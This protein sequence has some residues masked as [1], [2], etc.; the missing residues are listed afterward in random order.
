MSGW[1]LG[2]HAGVVHSVHLQAGRAISYRSRRIHTASAV[3]GGVSD[4]FVFGSSIFAFGPAALAHELSPELDTAQPV[5][6]AGQSRGLSACPKHDP[7]TGDL[8]LLALA[9][10]G[11]Q[12]HVTVSSGA[13]TRRIRPITD[14][15]HDVTDLA[16]TRDHIV[17]VADGFVGVTSQDNET[18][19]TWVATGVD[20]PALVHA[21]DNADAIVIHAITPS[22]ERWTVDTAA[23]NVRRDVLDTAPRRF[24]R[25]DERLPDRAPG[26][27]WTIGDGTA[28]T[29]DLGTGRD[30]HH[31]FGRRQPGDL[32]FIADPARPHD[33]DGGWLVGFVHEASGERTEL[34]VLDAADISRPA[35][36][37]VPIPR[38]ISPGIHTTWVPETNQ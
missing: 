7:T 35:V 33:A 10:D 29:H 15:S 34:V 14:A 36:A 12:A 25:T 30:V 11:T 5:D 17:F 24:A 18:R 31:S 9:T 38:P 20:A 6:L 3:C 27:L 32:V 26:F 37:T 19:I 16:I 1:L 2:A 8:H 13:L 21:H 4:I 23:L 28:D 22:L